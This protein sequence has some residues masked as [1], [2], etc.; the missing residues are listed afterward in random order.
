MH[1][2][3]DPAAESEVN[4]EEQ[5]RSRC[6]SLAETRSREKTNVE[7]EAETEQRGLP[8]V[9]TLTVHH[10]PETQHSAHQ[11]ARLEDFSLHKN[12]LEEQ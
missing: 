12:S 1:S 8:V 3:L 11:G 7:T 5:S 2:Q 9:H 10:L 4:N 6:S